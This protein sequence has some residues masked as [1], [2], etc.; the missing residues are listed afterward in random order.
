MDVAGEPKIHVHVTLSAMEQIADPID[1]VMSPNVNAAGDPRADDDAPL[2]VRPKLPKIRPLQ[3]ATQF[4][5][6]DHQ[7]SDEKQVH[8]GNDQIE[9]RGEVYARKGSTSTRSG[10]NLLCK[11]I[12]SN[13]LVGMRPPVVRNSIDRTADVNS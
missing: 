10:E 9:G 5:L 11:S 3:L 4:H 2:N 12:G 1:L 13:R 7:I 8:D 6:S